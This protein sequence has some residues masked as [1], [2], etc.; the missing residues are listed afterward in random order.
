MSIPKYS[1]LK[2]HTLGVELGLCWNH[3]SR[4]QNV[5][6]FTIFIENHSPRT[7]FLGKRGISPRACFA[8]VP[9][10]RPLLS[11]GVVIFHRHPGALR[12]VGGG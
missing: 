7:F 3:I 5:T 2:C 1:S 12:K 8:V 4:T 11:Q 9:Y 6:S 10:L